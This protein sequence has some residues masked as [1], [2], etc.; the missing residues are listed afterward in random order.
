[1]QR[2]NRDDI[3]FYI[4]LMHLSTLL[5][6]NIIILLYYGCSLHTPTTVKRDRTAEDTKCSLKQKINKLQKKKNFKFYNSRS[7]LYDV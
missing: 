6:C 5:I 4:F 7:T 3:S 2:P 1:V